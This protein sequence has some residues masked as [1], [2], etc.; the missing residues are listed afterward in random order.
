MGNYDDCNTSDQLLRTLEE[1]FTTYYRDK[2]K[3]VL[4][5]CFERNW[6]WNINFI[7]EVAY[8][9]YDS[10]LSDKVPPTD[11]F[12]KSGLFQRYIHSKIHSKIYN[13]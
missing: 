2:I 12:I 6:T 9:R 10:N 11:D 8:N 5:H 3:Y 1:R 7:S 4:D 13:L